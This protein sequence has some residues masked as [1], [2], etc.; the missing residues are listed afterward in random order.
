[1]KTHRVLLAALVLGAAGLVAHGQGK[2]AS[3]A[4]RQASLDLAAK[5]L[6]PRE[7]AAASL[8]AGLANPFNP[9]ASRKTGV[10]SSA[11]RSDREILEGIAARITPTGA[12]MFGNSP[13]L[14][15][16]EKKLKVGESLTIPFEGA[17]YLVVITE[18]T[19][20]S[21]RV[22]LNREEITRPIKPGKAP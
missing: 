10:S 15:L 5:L 22:R 11:A 16:R 21:F 17:D 20:T 13:L 1:M 19:P 4:K 14:L 12:M 7:N 8:P 9:T 3:P 6:A 18:I 2:I